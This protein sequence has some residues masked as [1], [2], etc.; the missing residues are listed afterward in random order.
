MGRSAVGKGKTVR[1]V[2]FYIFLFAFILRILFVVIQT[3]FS[4]FAISFYAPDSVV[5]DTI[6]Q[7]L[8][9]GTGYQWGNVPSAY[10]PPGYP[11]FLTLCYLLFG[12]N[13]LAVAL[14][15]CLL[16]ALSAV[17]VAW[18]GLLLFSRRTG[19][20]AGVLFALYPHSLF[21]TGAILTDTLYVFL[22]LLALGLLIR[23]KQTKSVGMLTAASVAFGLTLMTRSTL[24]PFIAFLLIFF[25]VVHRADGLKKYFFRSFLFLLILIPTMS[26]WIIRN[27]YTFHQLIITDSKG[28]I[29]LAEAFGPNATGGT[30]G[31]STAGIDYVQYPDLKGHDVEEADRYFA[32]ATLGIQQHP[33]RLLTSIPHKFWN[34]WRPNYANASLRNN[35]IFVPLYLFAVVFGIIGMVLCWVRLRHFLLLYLYIA[36]HVVIHSVMYGIIRYRL[37]VEPILLLFAAEGFL[38]AYDRIDIAH[39]GILERLLKYRRTAKLLPFIPRN[40]T[41][42]DIGCGKDASFLRI[43]QPRIRQ[44]I[45]I[46]LEMPKRTKEDKRLRFIRMNIQKKIPVTSSSCT[47]VVSLAV[48]GCFEHRTQLLRECYRVLRPNGMLL[49]TIP[50]PLNRWVM[51]VLWRIGLLDKHLVR[52]YRYYH[53]TQELREMLLKAGFTNIQFRKF[54]LGLNCLVMAQ[55]LD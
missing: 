4:P 38:Q 1:T 35:L 41:V 24:L 33:L 2:L 28:A 42:L 3:Y 18:I 15:Q 32:D 44:G 29:A 37:P 7:N 49:F 52:Q 9:A 14:F 5:Y 26:P 12:R 48:F 6:A 47:C 51:E 50:M 54:Q 21:W 53:T 34:M 43:I 40:A 17:L 30:G 39:K 46:D 36:Y 23:Y 13:F 8:V 16:G 55:K 31:D 20:V 19:Y 45:G 10:E 11:L 27:E 22:S 25:G